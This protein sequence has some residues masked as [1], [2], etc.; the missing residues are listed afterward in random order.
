MGT[1]WQ[2]L[3]TEAFRLRVKE[4]SAN[5]YPKSNEE[6][7]AMG[8]AGKR[9]EEMRAMTIA[10]FRVAQNETHIDEGRWVLPAC[11]CGGPGRRTR[12][13]RTSVPVYLKTSCVGK[14]AIA[15]AGRQH[16]LP[17]QDAVP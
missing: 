7:H 16:P 3:A 9:N 4:L 10:A 5:R 6:T 17:A 1:G 14:A 2:C 8:L 15:N 11:R 12:E 13:A